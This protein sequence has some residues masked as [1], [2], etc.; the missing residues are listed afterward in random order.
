MNY[1]AHQIEFEK[2]FFTEKQCIEYLMAIRWADGYTCSKCKS[3]QYW[4]TERNRIVCSEC[5]FQTTAIAGT[6]FEQTNKPLTLWYRAIW[7]M[8]AQKNGVSATG[9]QKILGLGSYTTAWSWLQKLRT[10]T[11]NPEREKLSGRIEID[12]TLVGGRSKGK[13]GRG[14]EKKVVVVIAVEVLEVGTGRVRIKLVPHATSKYL[15]D[16]IIA[17]VEQGSTITTDGLNSYKKIQEYG[18]LHKID[19]AIIKTDLEEL[20]P[21]VHRVASL[22]KRW[23]IGTH[24]NFVST[25]RMQ[26]Y[27][28]EFVFRYNRR[29]SKSRGLLFERIIE[30]AV[31][32]KP[33]GNNRVFKNR[34]TLQN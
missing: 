2:M 8:V 28:D 15:T 30:Q 29:K 20:L 31:K 13:R 3:K 16:F 26:Y 12:E 19:R 5:G 11:I 24:Q 23:L 17:N 25:G 14:A 9:L 34:M 18:Y 33:I 32:H 27:L 10:L 7:W 1:P 6:I 22:L 21:N 4:F